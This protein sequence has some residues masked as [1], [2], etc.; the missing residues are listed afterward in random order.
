MFKMT[1]V[2]LR[3]GD[4]KKYKYIYDAMLNIKISSDVSL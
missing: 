3:S 2:F 4:R 1:L